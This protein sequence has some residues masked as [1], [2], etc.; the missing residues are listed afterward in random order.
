TA[1]RPQ[2]R[3]AAEPREDGH[4]GVGR[5]LRRFG[6][7]RLAADVERRRDEGA[8]GRRV[9]A[10]AVAGDADDAGRDLRAELDDADGL[11]V[12]VDREARDERDADARRRKTL[13]DAVLVRAEHEVRLDAGRTDLV[14]HELG[15]SAGA[16]ADQWVL[17]DL[18]Q[19]RRALAGRERRVDGGDEHVVVAEELE[20]LERR[21]VDR[22]LD[23]GDVE[24]A[25]LDTVAEVR[26][27]M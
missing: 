7:R 15:R 27:E 20:G 6:R 18:A 14:D 1:A 16:V 25:A 2:R 19:G 4:G 26:V 17:A 22:E 10:V 24:V 3:P 13:D 5:G 11:V 23:E 12:L 8:G 21:V 9:V